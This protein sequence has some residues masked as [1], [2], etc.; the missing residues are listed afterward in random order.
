MPIQTQ[1]PIGF[2]GPGAGGQGTPVDAPMPTLGAEQLVNASVPFAFTEGALNN[3]TISGGDVAEVGIGE[4]FGGGGSGY[5]N[6]HAVMGPSPVTLYQTG[7][8]TAG[9]W[10]QLASDIDTHLSGKYHLRNGFGDSAQPA[11][12]ASFARSRRSSGSTS[13][14]VVSVD[15]T[16]DTDITFSGVSCK[17]ISSYLNGID[18]GSDS[19]ASIGAFDCPDNWNA[20]VWILGNSTTPSSYILAYID[21]DTGTIV[22][23]KVASNYTVTVLGSEAITYAKDAALQLYSE[24]DG[25]NVKVEYNGTL[26]NTYAAGVTGTYAGLFRTSEEVIITGGKVSAHPFDVAVLTSVNI[27]YL[28]GSITAGAS[29]S[30]RPLYAWYGRLNKWL[31]DTYDHYVYPVLQNAGV[32]GHSSWVGAVRLQSDVLDYDPDVVVV[33][34]AVNDTVSISGDRP[35]DFYPLRRP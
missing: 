18:T 3:W 26:L 2:F 29:A 21:R 19:H 23:I 8:M 20:G 35:M 31:I 6:I 1:F 13:F 4:G 10:F 11:R 14:V 25:V 24:D 17:E 9:H 27:V 22:T 28:G 7:K 15:N 32:G 33:E 34:F 12:S 16:Q 30:D 5:L